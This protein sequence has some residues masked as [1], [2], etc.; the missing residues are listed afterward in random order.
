MKKIA[1]VLLAGSGA[2][3][4]HSA[5]AADI[6]TTGVGISEPGVEQVRLVCDDFGQCYRTR[7]RLVIIDQDAYDYGPRDRY[8]ERRYYDD[9]PRVGVYGVPP[10]GGPG[11]SIGVEDDRW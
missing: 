8:I 4:A 11:I 6:S 7:P 10:F 9:G 5:M 1:I 2:L 3:L